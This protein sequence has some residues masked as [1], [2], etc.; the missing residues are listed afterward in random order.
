M[1]RKDIPD[2]LLGE[3]QRLRSVRKIEHVFKSAAIG[4]VISLSDWLT[5]LS[6]MEIKTTKIRK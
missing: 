5:D 6:Q 2:Q 1:S 3:T 4:W